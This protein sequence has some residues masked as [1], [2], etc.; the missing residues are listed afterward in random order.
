M[1]EREFDKRERNKR[2]KLKQAEAFEPHEQV[3]L[4]EGARAYAERTDNRW[5]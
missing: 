3:K 4:L 5:Y 2:N 1:T